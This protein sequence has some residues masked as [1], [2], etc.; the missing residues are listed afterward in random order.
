MPEWGYSPEYKA[1][2]DLSTGQW[3][4]RK[5]VQGWVTEN[6][7]LA[8]N[9]ADGLAQMMA[10]D[11]LRVG[12]WQAAMRQQIKQAY[13]QQYIAGKGGI[14][15]MTQADWGSIGG[16]LS[17]QFSYLDSFSQEIAA[18]NLSEASTNVP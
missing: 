12:D 15:Q 14:E 16:Q 9:A 3:A 18:G 5:Q 11:L 13:K 8:D 7:A 4:S 17:E 6:I 2:R 1:Y 10:D